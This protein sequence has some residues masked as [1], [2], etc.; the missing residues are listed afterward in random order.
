MVVDKALLCHCIL[1]L[2]VRNNISVVGFFEAVC[3]P[4]SIIVGCKT[5]ITI[6][7]M[8]CSI[9]G[10]QWSALLYVCR[11]SGRLVSKCGEILC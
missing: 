8:M 1:G 9:L 3:R 2:N 10:G 4:G 6:N 5:L 11:E 7:K